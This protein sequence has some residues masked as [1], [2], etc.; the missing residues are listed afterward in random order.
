M[1][2]IALIVPRQEMLDLAEQMIEETGIRIKYREVVTNRQAAQRACEV[3]AD[4]AD[5]IIARGHQAHLIKKTVSVPVVDIVMTAQEM[6]LLVLQARNLLNIPH[7]TIGIVGYANMFCDMSFFEQMY[8]IKLNCYFIQNDGPSAEAIEEAVRKAVDD[9]ADIVIGGDICT[10]CARRAGINSFF[11][12]PMAD[13][14]REAFGVAKR[15]AYASDLEK[16]N[17][18]ELKTLLDNSFCVF[19]R[20]DAAGNILLFNHVAEILLGWNAQDII[21]RPISEVTDAVDENMLNLVLHQ[22]QEIYSTFIRISKV[23]LVANLAPIEDRGVV[24][25]AILSCQDVVRVEKMG[26]TA[27][28]ELLKYGYAAPFRFELFEKPSKPLQ[29]AILDARMYAQSDA[30]VLICGEAGCEQELLAQ[31]IHNESARKD[32]PF[33]PFDCGALGGAQQVRGLF[34]STDRLHPELSTKGAAALANGGTLC[35]SNI[36]S[37]EPVCQIRLLHLIAKGNLISESTAPPLPVNVRVIA[38]CSGD[39]TLCVENGTFDKTLYY[40]VK[41]LSLD[42]PPL[43]D[44]PE[45]IRALGEKYILDACERYNRYIKLTSGA[46][47]QME[48]FGWDGNLLQFRSFCEN[49]VLVAPRRSIDENFV[50][51]LYCQM[52]PR[53]HSRGQQKRPES[54]RNPEAMQ[55]ADLLEKH[56]GNRSAM[57]AELGVS[58]T[59]LWRR[60]KKYDIMRRR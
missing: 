42:V 33:V 13:S 3:V 10:A 15:V 23:S 4:G 44:R 40:S 8:D 53:A 20:L 35:L 25:G 31:A 17:T 26:A 60:I 51:Q 54:F 37:L 1:A 57:A 32:G 27:Q 41:T 52:Y 48:E 38:V 21:G 59:T 6:G 43:R 56:H 9:K 39:L 47:K 29:K 22:G 28:R 34:G 45:D 2:D 55:I 11:L 46:K 50:S 16:K 5:I 7:P 12:T 49:M 14:I 36:A 19:V 18:A 30:P 24:T 58:T